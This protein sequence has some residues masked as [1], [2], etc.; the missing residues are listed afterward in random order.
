MILGVDF[1]FN[2]LLYEEIRKINND[3]PSPN[4]NILNQ[5]NLICLYTLIIDS[6]LIKY[7]ILH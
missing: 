7:S 6:I 2:H 4:C 1:S 3:L 5:Y